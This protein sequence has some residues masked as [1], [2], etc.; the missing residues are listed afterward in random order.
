MFTNDVR[1]DFE[2][3]LPLP[4]LCKQ[5][6]SFDALTIFRMTCSEFALDVSD[7]LW[8]SQLLPRSIRIL[9]S[10]DKTGIRRSETAS[11]DVI[12]GIQTSPPFDAGNQN[13]ANVVVKRFKTIELATVYFI[14]LFHRQASLYS[15]I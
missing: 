4:L 9:P 1:Q 2:K 14:D 8:K 11:Q 6:V 3:S 12:E 15:S 5:K 13:L 7:G 10:H